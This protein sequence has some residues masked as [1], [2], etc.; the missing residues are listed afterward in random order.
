MA[1]APSLPLAA[2]TPQACSAGTVELGLFGIILTLAGTIG[3]AF[4][5][6]LD[7]R[8]GSRRVIAATLL[9][10]I[11]SAVGVLSVDRDHVFFVLQVEPKISGSAPFALHWRAGLSRFRHSHRA[12][13]GSHPGVGAR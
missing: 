2:S 13:L 4:G 7:D 1:L 9:L 12:C 10:F 5:G 8:F 6:V 11:L 3:A